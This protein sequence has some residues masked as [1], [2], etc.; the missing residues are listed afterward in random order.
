MKFFVEYSYESIC[1][2]VLKEFKIMLTDRFEA[3]SVH[4]Q[5]ITGLEAKKFRIWFVHEDYLKQ[6]VHRSL[7]S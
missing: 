2:S 3:G 6:M 5:K 1:F 4:T 7:D